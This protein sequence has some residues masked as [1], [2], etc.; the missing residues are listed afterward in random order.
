MAQYYH[1]ISRFYSN[2]TSCLLSNLLQSV[3]TFY[4]L[5][6]F[7]DYLPDI[8]KNVLSLDF[9][10]VSSWL[11]LFDV[12]LG[13]S[14]QKVH[15]ATHPITDDATFGLL[16]DVVS[17]MSISPVKLLCAFC[18]FSIHYCYGVC[19][20]IF[21]FHHPFYIYQLDFYQHHLS[22]SLLFHCEFTFVLIQ[23]STSTFLLESSRFLP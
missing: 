15:N 10:G 18:S 9:S 11:N 2:F 14:H 5:D 17:A 22:K 8:L 6:I 4:Y 1:L 19:Q 13:S 20:M 21:C 12:L 23:K 3:F 16:V 7:K